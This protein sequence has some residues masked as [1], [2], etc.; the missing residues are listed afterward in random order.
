VIINNEIDRVS[1][2]GTDLNIAIWNKLYK[3]SIITDNHISFPD[4]YIYDDICFSEL[5]KHYVTQVYILEEFLYHHIISEDAASYSSKNWQNKLGFFDL[6]KIKIQ[7]LRVRDLYNMYSDRY[8][9]EFF[10][11]YISLIKNFLKTYGYMPPQILNEMKNQSIE[12]FPNYLEIP[13]VK[14]MLSGDAGEFY[15]L[16]CKGLNIEIDEIYIQKIISVL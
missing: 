4:G 16:V 3:K 12:L 10:I 6:Q 7:E 15:K 9:V 14:K 2:F 13:F 8:E 5:V 11:D 1:F